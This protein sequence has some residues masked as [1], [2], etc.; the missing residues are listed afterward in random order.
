MKRHFLFFWL[1]IVSFSPICGKD[2]AEL[3][4]VLPILETYINQ[5]MS[6]EGVP[7]AIV[8]IVKD[9]KVIYLKGFGVKIYG[10]KTR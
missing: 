2:R 1:F 4:T 7:G 3:S 8:V 9:G 6:A 10:K 5:A